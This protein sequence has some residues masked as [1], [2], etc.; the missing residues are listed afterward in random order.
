MKTPYYSFD[1]GAVHFTLLN[2]DIGNV[3]GKDVFWEKQKEWMVADLKKNQPAAMRILIFHHPPFTAVKRRQKE[4]AQIQELV[5][6]FEQNKVTAVFTGHDHNYQHHVKSGIHY[7]VTGG[8]GEP[9]L[10]PVDG[11][12]AGL[13]RKV[14]STEHFVQVRVEGRQAKVEAVALDGHIIDVIELR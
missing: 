9:P 8:G 10:Y 3:E 5:P 6:L 2:T 7:V 13:T 11:P 12:I 1:W 4:D 14:E